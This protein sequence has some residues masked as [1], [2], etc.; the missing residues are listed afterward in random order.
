MC[1]CLKLI[2][3]AAL[4]IIAISSAK[5]VLQI[6]KSAAVINTASKIVKKIGKM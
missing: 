1:K 6:A 5:A 4:V 3:A 2:K